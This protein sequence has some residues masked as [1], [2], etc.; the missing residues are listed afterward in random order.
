M[1]G[2]FLWSY[3][4]AYIIRLNGIKL[5]HTYMCATR[6]DADLCIAALRCA[7]PN[8]SVELWQGRDL[9]ANYI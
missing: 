5:V 9:I 3:T 2:R 8:R 6:E 1:L 4:M 7:H